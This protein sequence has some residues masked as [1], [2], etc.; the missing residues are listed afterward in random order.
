MISIKIPVCFV[1]CLESASNFFVNC[2]ISNAVAICVS[3]SFDG[4]C[5]GRVMIISGLGYILKPSRNANYLFIFK[6]FHN[7]HEFSLVIV[8]QFAYPNI[9]LLI[10]PR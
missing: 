9:G 10:F 8:Y 6:I 5:A 1:N 2:N 7:A 4:M 3:D